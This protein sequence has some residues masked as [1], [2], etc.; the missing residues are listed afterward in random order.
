VFPN[1]TL[2]GGIS[3]PLILFPKFFRLVTPK[4]EE[5]NLFASALEDGAISI[6]IGINPA[7]INNNTT[8]AMTGEAILGHNKQLRDNEIAH[9][10]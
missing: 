2:L 10:R 6:I 5:D 8:I 3:N 9:M 1:L 4:L 7:I